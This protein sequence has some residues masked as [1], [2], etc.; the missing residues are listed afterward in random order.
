MFHHVVLPLIRWNSSCL[1]FKDPQQHN[2]IDPLFTVVAIDGQGPESTLVHKSNSHRT[3]NPG[4]RPCVSFCRP[5][6]ID[7]DLLRSQ[8]RDLL[9]CPRQQGLV[10]YV[11]NHLLVE[12]DLHAHR[13]VSIP[14]ARHFPLTLTPPVAIAHLSKTRLHSKLA[15]LSSTRRGCH[16]HC[17]RR[18]RGRTTPVLSQ[19]F[20]F[21]HSTFS[22][23]LAGRNMSLR[24]DQQ[25]CFANV[26]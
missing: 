5:L 22:L 1:G 12:Q 25:L 13:A 3:S 8:L 20:H 4:N 23:G 6:L 24:N 26:S 17:C 11:A 15:H 18:S 2:I 10:N 7:A 19:A 16:S 9:I 14:S 21:L